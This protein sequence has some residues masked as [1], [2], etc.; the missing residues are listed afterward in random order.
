[1]LV[2]M[3]TVIELQVQKGSV[4]VFLRFDSINQLVF[5]DAEPRAVLV[6]CRDERRCGD[7]CSCQTQ[8]PQHHPCSAQTKLQE[9]VHALTAA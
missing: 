5:D 6:S 7:V 2:Q 3:P 1:M 8:P 4:R 9:A